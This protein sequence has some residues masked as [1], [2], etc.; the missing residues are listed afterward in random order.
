MTGTDSEA[1]L[2]FGGI[3]VPN[4]RRGYT[5]N[6][7]GSSW[8]ELA[9]MNTARDGFG[10]AGSGNPASLAF[11]GYLGPPG[12]ADK[13]QSATENWNGSSWT[14]VS[15]LSTPRSVN[16]GIGDT[17][18]E[19][20]YAG[21]YSPTAP[22]G[23]IAKNEIWDGV[24]WR[25]VADLNTARGNNAASGT[26]TAGFVFSGEHPPGATTSS[27]EWSGNTITTKVLTD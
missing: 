8:T 1:A 14:E 3:D 9:D 5:E 7:N 18:T 10:S 16:A 24:S 22:N 2:Y 26:S 11:G 4:N 25:E 6:W 12:T 20:L 13:Y 27:E 15:D 17:A 23:Y 19:A 21:G